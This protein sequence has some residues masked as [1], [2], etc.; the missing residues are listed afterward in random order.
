[1]S[2]TCNYTYNPKIIFYNKDT[3]WGGGGRVDRRRQ[4]SDLYLCQIQ[5]PSAAE[6]SSSTAAVPIP[7]LD[8]AQDRTACLIQR[9]LGLHCQQLSQSHSCT[10]VIVREDLVSVPPFILLKMPAC[11]D[12]NYFTATT[13]PSRESTFSKTS[14]PVT[15]LSQKWTI[16]WGSP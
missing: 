13:K 3:I 11:Q 2:D 5:T 10:L 1:M 14:L 9:K 15:W 4:G 6:N 7:V 16:H 12:Q 8:S